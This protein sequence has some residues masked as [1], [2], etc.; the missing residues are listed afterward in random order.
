LLNNDPR[1]RQN[2]R[3]KEMKLEVFY[4]PG[5]GACDSLMDWLEWKEALV[6]AKNVKSNEDAM[7]EGMALGAGVWPVCR[8]GKR[9]VVG[10]DWE[11]IE[12]LLA[13]FESVGGG[14][15]VEL[16]ASGEAVVVEVAQE[17]PAGRAGLQAG[18]VISGLGGY[19]TL[20][21]SIDQLRNVF[22]RNDRAFD[23]QVKRDGRI[24]SLTLT[25]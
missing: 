18:D 15:A 23:L 11:A 9:V 8:K 21:L 16:A 3:I 14:V 1:G 17:S 12:A 22:G 6:L 20:S 5:H 7:Y 24:Q 19:S 10:L 4:V 2:G 25:P 13:P